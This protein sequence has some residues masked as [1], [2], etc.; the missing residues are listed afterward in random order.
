MALLAVHDHLLELDT[1]LCVFTSRQSSIYIDG[2]NPVAVSLT[3][4]S[5]ITE[6]PFDGLFLLPFAAETQIQRYFNVTLKQSGRVFS[7]LIYFLRSE[8][9]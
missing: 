2:Y 4:R 7:E 8:H 3:E 6:L 9:G 5:A 1:L